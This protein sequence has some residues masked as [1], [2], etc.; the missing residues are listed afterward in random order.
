VGEVL[1]LMRCSLGCGG[2]VLAAWLETGPVAQSARATASCATAGA[3]GEGVRGLPV[4][5]G[6]GA[7]ASFG[8]GSIGIVRRLLIRFF[9]FA[10]LV[11]LT[12]TI[13]ARPLSSA[14]KQLSSLGIAASSG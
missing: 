13:F 5:R 3:G 12:D 7:V 10:L 9:L 14:C 11:E 6:P 1:R 8:R 2:R 4:Q